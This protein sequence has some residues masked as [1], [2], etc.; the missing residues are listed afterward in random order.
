MAIEQVTEFPAELPYGVMRPIII[1]EI[2]GLVQ[3]IRRLP[4]GATPTRPFLIGGPLGRYAS[5]IG[6]TGV[7]LLKPPSHFPCHIEITWEGR[8]RFFQIREVK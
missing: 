8:P 4:A 5:M 6:A 7:V 1:G 2:V 3:R